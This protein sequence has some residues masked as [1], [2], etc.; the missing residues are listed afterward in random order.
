MSAAVMMSTSLSSSILRPSS[1]SVPSNRTT[2]GTVNPT[3]LLASMIAVAIVVHR[4]IPPKMLTNTPL[5]FGSS[6]KIRNASV[7]CSVFAPPP[8]SKK[9]A[10]RPPWYLMMSIVDI[11]NPAPL[12]KQPMFPSNLTYDKPCSD[13]R[14]SLGSSSLKSRY[15]SRSLWRYNAFESNVILASNAIICPSPVMTNGLISQSE[16]S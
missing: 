12:T 2:N 5:Q 3:V 11:A 13:A 7:T 8:T 1:T 6:N 9:F 4:A 14:T 15:C 16:Q 10:G